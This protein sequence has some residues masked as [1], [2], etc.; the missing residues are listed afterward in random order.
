MCTAASARLFA[1]DTEVNGLR[2]TAA[3]WRFLLILLGKI[4]FSFQPDNDTHYVTLQHHLTSDALVRFLRD[5]V[6]ASRYTFLSLTMIDFASQFLTE[7]A[8]I[9]AE[10]VSI[11][12]NAKVRLERLAVLQPHRNYLWAVTVLEG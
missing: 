11:H 9:N 4:I 3:I 7:E 10:I 6:T 2:R 12:F 5:N 1:T 8:C